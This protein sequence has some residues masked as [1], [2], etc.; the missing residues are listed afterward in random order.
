MASEVRLKCWG[1]ARDVLSS[2]AQAL[3]EQRVSICIG[4]MADANSIERA[5]TGVNAVFSI[6][7]SLGQGETYR[8]TDEQEVL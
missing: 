5:M 4:D 6:L 2:R 8:V 3:A 7:P 1:L